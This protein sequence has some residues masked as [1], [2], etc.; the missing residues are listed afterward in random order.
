MSQHADLAKEAQGAPPGP[1]EG[2]SFVEPPT[3][4][5]GPAPSLNILPMDALPEAAKADPN[6]REGNGSM[7]AINQPHLAQKY[8]VIRNGQP[9]PPQQLSPE[10]GRQLRP[11][12][13][14][15]IQRIQELQ[16]QQQTDEMPPG[17]PSTEMSDAGKAAATV[18]NMPGDT[19][20]K[21]LNPEE[22]K[23]LEKT[24]GRMDE[25]QFDAWRQAMMKDILNN[26]E[27]KEIIEER[28]E[29]MDVGDLVTEGYIVQEVVIVPN[30]FR[31]SFKTF[32][33]ETDLALK[34]LIME[35]TNTLGEVTERYYLDRFSFM[36]AAASLHAING[37]VIP[38]HRDDQGNFSDELFRKKF[39][40]VLK[41]PL[42]MLASVG[43]N[44]MWFESRVRALFKAEKLGNG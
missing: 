15:D 44:A 11:E 38:D 8:G 5:P 41:Q 14:R 29:P 10:G 4:A 33:G 24:L 2:G 21:P 9:V 17:S 37:K 35:D 39:N 18:G 36:A 22:Q 32:D 23:A 7:F 26:P 20:E 12:T 40:F 25:F 16:R 30:K 28:L 19:D 34:R 3:A 13:V 27:Q 6:F 1:V 42:H 43:L 31:V